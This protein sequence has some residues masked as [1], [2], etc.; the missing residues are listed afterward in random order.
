MVRTAVTQKTGEHQNFPHLLKV[1]IMGGYPGRQDQNRKSVLV[2][3]LTR[4]TLILKMVLIISVVHFLA[5]VFLKNFWQNT[6]GMWHRL[7]YRQEITGRNLL[8]MMVM[9]I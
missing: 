4:I 7:G 2:L 8:F 9:S 5:H 3:L 6:S 1:I